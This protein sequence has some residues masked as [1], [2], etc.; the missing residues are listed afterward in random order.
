MLTE[1]PD[2]VQCVVAPHPSIHHEEASHG[3][4]AVVLAAA[5]K[6]PLRLLPAGND[7]D[8]YR[9]GGDIFQ[10]LKESN[11]Q[12]DVIDFPEMQHGWVIRGDTADEAVRRD[13]DLAMDLLV[14]Y[15]DRFLH[16]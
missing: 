11:E 6:C 10:K 13:V 4:D 5:V 1:Y 3:R 16:T 9:E 8:R 7:T 14:E 12:S 2:R 15:V